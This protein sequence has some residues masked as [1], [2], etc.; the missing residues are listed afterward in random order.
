MTIQF[1]CSTPTFPLT[2]GEAGRGRRLI[3]IHHPPALREGEVL[4]AVFTNRDYTK[5]R[6]SG[7]I[8]R[9]GPTRIIAEGSWAHGDAGATA[10]GP[11]QLLAVRPGA[12]WLAVGGDGV[13]WWGM[14][15]ADGTIHKMN[16]T[17]RNDDPQTAAPFVRELVAL[18][19]FPPTSKWRAWLAE[20]EAAFGGAPTPIP[21]ILSTSEERART[22]SDATR[23]LPLRA[24]VGAVFAADETARLTPEE[25]TLLTTLI[26]MDPTR[27]RA[28]LGELAERVRL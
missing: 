11:D 14:C 25:Q 27:R 16:V 21:T 3:T 15:R 9:H 22:I 4:V 20:H 5:W 23:V 6:R 2:L 18:P 19:D 10:S 1:E 26:G 8:E 13:A 28:L 24:A 17:E 7:K 12:C